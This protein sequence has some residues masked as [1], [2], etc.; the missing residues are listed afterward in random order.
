MNTRMSVCIVRRL[1]Q[2]SHI[3]LSLLELAENDLTGRTA[4]DELTDS[5]PAEQGSY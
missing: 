5:D 4:G 3:A 2:K 1:P